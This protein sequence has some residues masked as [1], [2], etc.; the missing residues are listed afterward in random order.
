MLIRKGFLDDKDVELIYFYSGDYFF[1]NLLILELYLFYVYIGGKVFK[2]FVYQVVYKVLNG[3]F[4]YV[5]YMW[6]VY[7]W[8]FVFVVNFSKEKDYLVVFKKDRQERI[9]MVLINYFEVDRLVVIGDIL[10][11]RILFF[12]LFFYVLFGDVYFM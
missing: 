5:V 8:I 3:V 11:I 2:S 10:L 6:I 7:I 9:D 12:D 4:Y 1:G